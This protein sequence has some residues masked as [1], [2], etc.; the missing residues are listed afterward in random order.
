MCDNQKEVGTLK[1][2]DCIAEVCGTNAAADPRFPRNAFCV[3]S[4]VNNPAEFTVF[5]PFETEGHAREYGGNA[6]VVLPMIVPG[7]SQS[8]LHSELVHQQQTIDA[9]NTELRLMIEQR[10]LAIRQR[11][12]ARVFSEGQ[13]E[14]AD[15]LR[16]SY[17]R[18]KLAYEDRGQTLIAVRQQLCELSSYHA[19]AQLLQDIKAF[20]LGFEDSEDNGPTVR[21]LLAQID[22]ALV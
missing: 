2:G 19:H 22:A 8:I 4:M 10:N 13:Q 18:L 12:E 6:S 17:E 7:S 3:A 11:D 20:L 15:S 9:L 21:G 5:G 16:R 14:G 1:Q